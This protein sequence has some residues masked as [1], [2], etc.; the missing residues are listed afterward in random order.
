MKHTDKR[1]YKE[2]SNGEV[3]LPRKVLRY[4]LFRVSHLRDMRHNYIGILKSESFADY[5]EEVREV[6]AHEISLI[7]VAILNRKKLCAEVM[8]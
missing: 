2:F 3:N 7:D 1:I 6:A 5:P 4:M 8:E